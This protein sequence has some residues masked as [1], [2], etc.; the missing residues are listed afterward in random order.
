MRITVVYN[1]PEFSYY[2]TAGEREAVEG[3][4]VEAAAVQQ[5]LENLGFE[6]SCLGL[7]LPPEDAGHDLENLE[8][9]LVFNLFEG[10]AGHPGSET[11][12]PQ[13]LTDLGIRYTGCP[14][15]ALRSGL[16]KAETKRILGA[17]GVRTPR[18]QVL[19]ADTVSRF[20]LDF[21]CIVKPAGEDASHGITEESVVYN[22]QSLQNRLEKVYNLYKNSEIL[23]EEYIS[24]R[25]F[26]ATVIGNTIPRVLAVSEIVF[27]LPPG[28]PEII[29]YE[30][31]WNK[32]SVY[33]RGTT[34][35]C[36]AELTG[37]ADGPA[38]QCLCT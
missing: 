3:V 14:P 21:P 20:N 28:M 22:Y 19:S 35:V 9:D 13:L 17:G 31:K 29:T 12:I 23:V 2:D 18:A 16:N 27:S 7:G 24:G 34:P 4:V 36:P 8:T 26:N 37:Y 38:G 30:G 10:F 15:Q 1:L 25:E 11:D 5:A 33:Y 32:D 6:T